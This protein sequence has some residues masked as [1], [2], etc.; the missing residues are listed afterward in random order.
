MM[1]L[2]PLEVRKK[3]GDFRRQIRGYDPES[4]DDFL[5]LAADRL[6][7][8]VREN[9]ALAEKAGRLEEQVKEYRERE[10]A[11]TEAL[12]SAQ[13]MRAEVRAQAAREADQARSEAASEVEAARREA[14]AAL[15][16]A[17]QKAERELAEARQ[18]VAEETTQLSA[19]LSQMKERETAAI[20]RLRTR[21]AEL[22]RSY[23]SLLDREFNELE[24]VARSVEQL[25]D[26]E[27]SG[28]EVGD[29]ELSA[30]TAALLEA[31]AA[32]LSAAGFAGLEDEFLA[33]EDPNADDSDDPAG[34]EETAAPIEAVAENDAAGE[35]L[36]LDEVEETDVA[37]LLREAVV[38]ADVPVGALSS[39]APADPVQAEDDV[40]ELILADAEGPAAADLVLDEVEGDDVSW[41]EE[42]TADVPAAVMP[43]T[44]APAAKPAWAQ[45]DIAPD[46]SDEDFINDIISQAGVSPQMAGAAPPPP[47]AAS[48][49]DFEDLLLDDDVDDLDALAARLEEGPV[50]AA[51]ALDGGA[52]ASAVAAALDDTDVLFE[53]DAGPD[54]EVAE[55]AAGEELA[56]SVDESSFDAMFEAGEEEAAEFDFDKALAR[57]TGVSAQTAA[58]G[59]ENAKPARETFD[60]GVEF[61]GGPSP[62]ELGRNGAGA[63]SVDDFTVRPNGGAFQPAGRSSDLTLRP[64]SPQ[65]EAP[66]LPLESRNPEDD[67]GDDMFTSMFSGRR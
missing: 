28:D 29:D 30:D 36:I 59:K 27:A 41:L 61:D 26:S 23:R 20:A 39:A 56:G 12:V 31:T 64:L 21:R 2:T 54:G 19:R 42:L 3:K 57:A 25:E 49:G 13:Q 63:F 62:L 5:D 17:R 38:E 24:A 48:S 6:E 16:D 46:L 7:A 50:E 45:T 66:D 4:V 11:L 10:K 9:L 18:R 60:L 58:R 33:L 34:D 15:E 22:L 8:V 32:T 1:D 47:A 40:A 52:E 43:E 14:R 37:D 35:A 51:P 55:V 67:R 53:D 65:E 44:E